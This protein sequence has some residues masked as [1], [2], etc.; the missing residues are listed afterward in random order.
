MKLGEILRKAVRS[1]DLPAR[2]GGEE[3]V[4]MMT[5]ANKGQAYTTADNLRKIV[6]ST[7]FRIPGQE[8]PLKVTVSGGVATYP[9]DGGTTTDLLRMADESLYEAKQSG[10]NRITLRKEFGLDGKPLLLGN[11]STG[12]EPL[13]R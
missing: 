11:R 5:S 8:S 9:Q 12:K 4:V 7:E 3:F 6:E 2:F 13:P 10:R 1:S